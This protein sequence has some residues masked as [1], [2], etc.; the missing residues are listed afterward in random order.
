MINSIAGLE[1]A[2][3]I[4]YGYAIEYD[5]SNTLQIKKT[6]ETKTI[7]NLFLGGQINGTT[8]YEVFAYERCG[9]RNKR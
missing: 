7:E 4:R 6:L 5:Y 9:T 2:K 1:N 3:V 8:G